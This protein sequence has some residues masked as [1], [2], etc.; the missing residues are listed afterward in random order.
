MSSAHDSSHTSAPLP[1]HI[2]IQPG[3]FLDAFHV[4]KLSD[5]PFVA[6]VGKMFPDGFNIPN[7][8]TAIA[9]DTNTGDKVGYI[10]YL[11]DDLGTG[12]RWIKTI[13][14]SENYQRQGIGFPLLRYA[15]DHIPGD[16][17]IYTT[18]LSEEFF[19]LCKRIEDP[20]LK[21]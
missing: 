1:P 2:T 19:K 10:H 15:L 5:D 18:A 8:Y 16:D 3:E 4:N 6:L 9:I 14:V 12:K 7:S 21:Y 11:T 20:R 17:P 13:Q